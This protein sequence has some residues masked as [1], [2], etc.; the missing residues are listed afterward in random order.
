M[1]NTDAHNPAIKP[2]K[3]MTKEQFVKNNRGLDQGSDLPREFLERIYDRLCSI[4]FV[5]ARISGAN[6]RQAVPHFSCGLMHTHCRIV[7]NEI[8]MQ[9]FKHDPTDKSILTYTNP[10]KAGWLKKQSGRV[11][12]WNERWFVLKDECIYYFRK[13][14]VWGQ[15]SGY[16]LGLSF[17]LFHTI[18]SVSC[19]VERC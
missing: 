10:D 17:F 16:W 11:R 4:L 8:V 12:A 2:Q 3:K 9:P 13:P 19:G 18:L 6:M 15:V 1:L 14:P 7:A 5:V